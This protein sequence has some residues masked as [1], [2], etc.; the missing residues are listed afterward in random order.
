MITYLSEQLF[1]IYF[2][3]FSSYKPEL[4]IGFFTLLVIFTISLEK[5]SLKMRN[6]KLAEDKSEKEKKFY[7]YY[8]IFQT[9]Y[10]VLVQKYNDLVSKYHDLKKEF[11]IFSKA[12]HEPGNKRRK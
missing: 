1:L 11:Y 8:V 2:F 4:V 9:E 10:I 5:V 12:H 7:D 6:K 3:N